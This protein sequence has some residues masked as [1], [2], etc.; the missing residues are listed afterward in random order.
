M[1][2]ETLF[3]STK[4]E[5]LEALS[6]NPMTPLEISRTLNTSI[7]NVSQQL[8]L[9]ELAGLV[10]K[11][12]LPRSQGNERRIVYSISKPISYSIIASNKNA[13]KEFIELNP[14]REALLSAWMMQ[15]KAYARI[16]EDFLLLHFYKIS[17]FDYIAFDPANATLY[18]DGKEKVKEKAIGK[19]SSVTILVEKRELSSL[20]IEG[21]D[22]NVLYASF[23]ANENS[24][25]RNSISTGVTRNR[26]NSG[27]GS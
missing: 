11:K 4:W 6:Q 19:E 15:D 27:G 22:I 21:S 16:V 24:A 20:I 2:N 9:L 3:T 17:D 10:M 14:E 7:A 25:Q 18:Y 23:N 1:E 5:V 12:R 13:R 8:R 26:R